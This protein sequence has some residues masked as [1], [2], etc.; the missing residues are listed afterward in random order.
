MKIRLILLL[1]TAV[2]V[3]V[4]AASPVKVKTL[5]VDPQA[6]APSGP[7]E[8]DIYRATDGKWYGYTGGAWVDMR[9]G[10]GSFV[11]IINPTAAGT[12]STWG[13]T[14]SSS[15][16]TYTGKLIPDTALGVTVTAAG[17][18]VANGATLIP[19]VLTAT[20]S[21]APP[22]TTPTYATQFG[23]VGGLFNYIR[24][25]GT[26]VQPITSVVAGNAGVVVATSGSDATVTAN[27]SASV[28]NVGQLAVVPNATTPTTALDLKYVSAN[29]TDNVAK[30]ITILP[31]GASATTYT[32]NMTVN[33]QVN[34]LDTG[35][36]AA[37][38]W[39]YV[40]LISNGTTHG[41]LA[42][43][44]ATAPTMPS[45]Y[46]FR[47]RVGAFKTDGAAV[48]IP[49]AQ[50]G[51]WVMYDDR[52]ATQVLYVTTSATGFTDVACGAFVPPIS[53]IGLFFV[54]SYP[55]TIGNL[56]I[57]RRNGAPGTV[58]A[59]EVPALVAGQWHV[60]V[61][62]CATDASQVIEYKSTESSDDSLLQLSGFYMP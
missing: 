30:S 60:G 53:T 23:F 11:D 38:T 44:S 50:N 33:G 48:V 1:F 51:H 12:G 27:V 18:G 2:T 43:A 42:S 61:Y 7:A 13:L 31:G 45:G 17:I 4:F 62:P 41:G 52:A 47:C 25:D 16:G 37:S 26:R 46:T 34:R 59:N 20:T 40:Y 28:G 56:L 3:A 32:I 21:F 24:G 6:S 29:L 57:I 39:Y 14:W 58:S 36:L 49:Y 5:G 19:G 54:A 35:S 10:S 22:N 8:G 55:T 15:S 9:P